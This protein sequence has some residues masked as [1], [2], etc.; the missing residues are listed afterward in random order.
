MSKAVKMAA[1]IGV[2]VLANLGAAGGQAP[3]A[4]AN[5]LPWVD[6]L[7]IGTTSF[8]YRQSWED[9]KPRLK[10]TTALAVIEDPA[11]QAF[12]AE[13]QRLVQRGDPPGAVLQ[14]MLSCFRQELVVA[15]GPA[16]AADDMAGGEDPG[17]QRVLI[18]R[19][20]PAGKAEF[21]KQYEAAAK[22]M[23]D[24]ATDQKVQ[25]GKIAFQPARH[26]GHAFAFQ[27]DSFYWLVPSKG[28]SPSPLEAEGAKHLAD[29]PMFKTVTSALCSRQKDKPVALFYHDLRP[30]W[31]RLAKKEASGWDQLSWRCVEAV[32]G[33]T[34]VEGKGYCNRY[35]W[36]VGPKRTGLLKHTLK[37]RVNAEWLKRVPADATG[38]VTGMWDPTS[39]VLS[40][41]GLVGGGHAM[42][43][44]PE[45]LK[46]GGQ[47]SNL[48]RA[49]GPRYLAYRQP[50]R[51]GSFV[52]GDMIPLNGTVAVAEVPDPAAL[53]TALGAIFDG[54]GGT[55]GIAL[56]TKKVMG[57]TVRSI[58]LMYLTLYLAELDHEVLLTSSAQLLK[59]AM[60]NWDK[61]APAIVDTEAYKAARAKSLPD[62]CF[63]LYIAPGG[64]ARGYMN[65]YVPIAQQGLALM[66]GMSR[67]F[68]A[69]KVDPAAKEAPGFD[70]LALPRGS[71]IARHITEGTILTA[72]DDGQAVIFEGYAPVLCL[73][74]YWVSAYSLGKLSPGSFT[75]MMQVFQYIA[76][77]VVAGEGGKGSPQV[78]HRLE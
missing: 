24:P 18:A 45:T 77:P 78:E 34:F 61:P 40:I 63:M 4:P 11:V 76:K 53:N 68:G 32:G 33:A 56:Q 7:D 39:V 13:V 47:L 62:A 67:G 17:P 21:T 75:D 15:A 6:K 59:D 37:G 1:V 42:D 14:F 27:D 74:Y 43:D 55:S 25:V 8:L 46:E 54:K 29:S 20:G 72:W 58:N 52:M 10:G 36:Q 60:E 69:E 49:I 41:V 9:T 2:A 44:L 64:L 22:V 57:H 19:F 31:K 12:F 65:Q 70:P 26:G 35:Y 16:A 38:F 71:D 28:K 66:E 5:Q 73:P 50:G 48:L 51:Y 23:S 30:T 3:P